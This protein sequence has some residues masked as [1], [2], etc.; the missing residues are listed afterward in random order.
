M[1]PFAS[2]IDASFSTE[3]KSQSSIMASVEAFKSAVV[4]IRDILRG[5]GVAITGMDSMRHICLYLLSR[6]MTKD[7]VKSLG[8]PDEF[9]WENLIE[10]AQTKNGGVQKALD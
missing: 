10:T 5:P 7:K 6:Y 1:P 9:A 2:K 3:T 4:R 8:V